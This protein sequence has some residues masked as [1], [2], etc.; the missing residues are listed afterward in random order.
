M[1]ALLFILA[2]AVAAWFAIG[3]IA[4]HSRPRRH[5]AANRATR[6]GDRR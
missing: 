2:A 6:R 4:D 5:R 3:V 1:I